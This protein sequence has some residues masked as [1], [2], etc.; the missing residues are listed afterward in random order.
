MGKVGATIARTPAVAP[1]GI[2]ESSPAQDQA[3]LRGF[4]G[5]S[6]GHRPP[7]PMETSGRDLFPLPRPFLDS[8]FGA[9]TVGV[10]ARDIAYLSRSVRRR[11]LKRL[12]TMQWCN[13]AVGTLNE[14]SGAPFSSLPLCAQNN[15][16]LSCL[17]KIRAI[18]LAVPSPVDGLSPAGAF[19]EL[20]GSSTRY[21]PMAATGVAPYDRDLVSWPD[22]G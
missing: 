9:S 11:V 17:D 7:P 18:F 22:V 2:S 10:P 3:Y 5:F 15:G 13:D 19:T 8:E 6:P 12:H 20:C 16:Q 1:E 4:P 21:S 14:L